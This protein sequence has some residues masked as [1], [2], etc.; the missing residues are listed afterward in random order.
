MTPEQ[1]SWYAAH[2]GWYRE[3][4][5]EALIA[6]KAAPH[7]YDDYR[8]EG[9]L[10]DTQPCTCWKASFMSFTIPEGAPFPVKYDFHR[11]AQT[12]T[13]E[14]DGLPIDTTENFKIF[15]NY[16]GIKL[17]GMFK[18]FTQITESPQSACDSVEQLSHSEPPQSES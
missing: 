18:Q 6:I 4:W 17:E 1:A 13:L 14:A 2:Y 9:C 11:I 7:D 10:G 12:L 15:V 8:D 5:K 3:R 16:L